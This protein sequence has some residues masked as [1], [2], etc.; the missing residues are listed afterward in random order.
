M[1][2]SDRS[3]PRLR[4]AAAIR[5]IP[6]L[7]VA[8]ALLVAAGAVAAVLLLRDDRSDLVRSARELAVDS[9]ELLAT[10]AHAGDGARARL[11]LAR[12]LVAAELGSGAGSVTA[13]DD[14]ELARARLETARDLASAVLAARPASWQAA[15]IVGTATYLSWSRARDPRLLQEYR[16][17][18]APLL[19]ARSLAPQRDEPVR[20]LVGAYLELWPALSEAKR[21]RARELAARAFRDRTTFER[22]GD[23]W[24]AVAGTGPAALEAVPDRPWAW[25]HLASALVGRQDWSGYCMAHD[26]A[27]DALERDLRERLTA[28]RRLAERGEP[29]A[30]R[31]ALFGVVADAPPELRFAHL[32]DRALRAVPPGP[33]TRE[34]A[35]ALRDWLRWQLDSGAG[36]PLDRLGRGPDAAGDG[37]EGAGT[38][39]EPA[40]L[41]FAA[42]A[43]L[44]SAAFPG[45]AERRDLPLA[46]RAALATPGDGANPIVRADRI[47][48][49]ADAPWSPEWARYFIDKART[50]IAEG[51]LAEA[52]ETLDR[53]HP[54]SRDHPLY[55]LALHEWRE[56]SARGPRDAAAGDPAIAS[57][58]RLSS[59]A[60]RGTDWSWNGPEAELL[61]LVRPPVTGTGFRVRIAEAPPPGAA[62]EISVDGAA[63]GCRPVRTG[64]VVS[65]S[66]PIVPG[67]H[68][69]SLR[70]LG[71]GQVW[72]GQVELVGSAPPA[73]S[74]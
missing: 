30:A 60:W 8:A 40:G 72:P 41:S 31:S 51:R 63:T 73:G 32:V 66:A 21:E 22:L 44:R 69:I 7:A 52:R 38:P 65:V 61:A 59:R 68:R 50:L 10:I 39:G 62:I 15:T 34:V 49:R 54:S 46:A 47:E 36:H 67:L 53:V 64:D 18:E 37:A 19:L 33:A 20:A 5:V 58:A 48:R 71:G 17:W 6:A 11:A 27:R 57:L 43:R 12:G 4:H 23:S 3:S 24:L 45:G 35:P 55:W 14:P 42:I 13:A 74:E 56:S 9:P 2:D 16:R 70:T 25:Q 28:G 29:L 1:A 26:R